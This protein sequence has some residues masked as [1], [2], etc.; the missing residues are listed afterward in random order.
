MN[1]EVVFGVKSPDIEEAYVWVERATGL[2][3][4]ARENDAWGGNYYAFGKRNGQ[5]LLLV[6]NSDPIDG[7][8]IRDF[9]D[10][11]VILLVEGTDAA[12]PALQGIEMDSN[13]FEKLSTKS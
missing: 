9:P 3:A 1:M 13:H 8:P 10:W 6:N 11:S 4:E 2:V 5:Q 12:S 7:E